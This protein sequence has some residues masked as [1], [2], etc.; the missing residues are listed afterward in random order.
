MK[1][2]NEAVYQTINPEE[3]KLLR[4][5]GFEYDKEDKIYEFVYSQELGLILSELRQ[6]HK[7]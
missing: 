3:A 7:V 4:K 6:E 2:K 5:L 1:K